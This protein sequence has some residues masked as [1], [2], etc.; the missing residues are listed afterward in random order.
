MKKL[1]LVQIITLMMVLSVFPFAHSDPYLGADIVRP[2]NDYDGISNYGDF[3]DRQANCA[4]FEPSHPEIYPNAISTAWD[5]G[6]PSNYNAHCFMVTYVEDLTRGFW[7]IG[8]NAKNDGRLMSPKWYRNIELL[9]EI[10]IATSGMDRLSSKVIRV[11]ASDDKVNYGFLRVWIPKSDTYWV[12]YTWIND[13]AECTEDGWQPGDDCNDM[14]NWYDANIMI[15]SVFFDTRVGD[16]DD[17]DDD[18]DSDDKGK[19]KK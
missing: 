6:G 16:D 10:G 15:D 1:I 14:D 19:K 13:K 18:S 3:S 7:K 12:T 4:W 17:D 2:A 9:V 11:R 8:L 5:H